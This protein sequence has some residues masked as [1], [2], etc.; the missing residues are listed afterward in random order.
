MPHRP[1][2]GRTGELGCD[3]KIKRRPC[4]IRR[5]RGIE[6]RSLPG[7]RRRTLVQLGRASLATALWL[8]AG[9]SHAH[10]PVFGLVPHTLFK[11][12][13]EVHGGYARAEAGAEREQEYALAAS[14]GLTADWTVGLEQHFADVSAPGNKRSGR[15]DV[16]LQSKYRFLR[17]DLPGAQRAA[18]LA[19]RLVLGGSGERELANEGAT[20]AIVGWS[21][22]YEGRRWYRW[23]AAPYRR[24][25]ENDAGFKRGDV[26]LLDLAGGLRFH[27]SGYFEPDWVW[28]L[29]LNGELIDR[30]QT[31]GNTVVAS[32]GQRWFVSPGLMLTY[33]NYALKTGV[34]IP[35][36]QNLNGAQDKIDYRGVV[37]I[38]GHF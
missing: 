25:A 27:P 8:Y 13:T 7:I 24:N 21:Y 36:S 11:G 14:Y 23:A 9:F 12:G 38:E 6:L 15:G 32:G 37:E 18:A 10:D 17:Q 4:N 33:R 30:A 29:E 28:M 34:Q 26:W 5:S 19:L 2:A 1:V 22:G 3:I 20:D 31:N 16:A 35:I